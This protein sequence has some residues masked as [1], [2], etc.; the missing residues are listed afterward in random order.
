MRMLRCQPLPRADLLA[1]HAPDAALMMEV[2]WARRTAASISIDFG[3][4]FQD[5]RCT[6]RVSQMRAFMR[7]M[8]LINKAAMP[9]FGREDCH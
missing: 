4:A 5:V 9:Y 6:P 1:S 8:M 2:T 7:A 3:Q